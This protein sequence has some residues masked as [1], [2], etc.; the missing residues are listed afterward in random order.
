MFSPLG[1]LGLAIELYALLVVARMIMSWFPLPP[2]SRWEPVFGFVYSATEPPLA[3]I[4]SVVPPVRL[5]MAA[6]D[7]SPLLL[8]LALQLISA[9]VIR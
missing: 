2:G 7:L 1:L 5:G 4:R 8:L 9:I 3:A 6:L